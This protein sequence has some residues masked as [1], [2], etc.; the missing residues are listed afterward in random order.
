MEAFLRRHREEVAAAGGEQ[1]PTL[2]ER[3]KDFMKYAGSVEM[4]EDAAQQV[5][6]YL[7]G[8]PKR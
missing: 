4:P 5:D 7:Y 8:T 3:L 6:H 1:M 2:A